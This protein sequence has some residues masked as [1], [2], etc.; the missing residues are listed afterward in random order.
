MNFI[1]S[2]CHLDFPKFHADLEQTVERAF[3]AGAVALIN[4]GV[5]LPTSQSSVALASRYRPIYAAVGIHPHDARTLSSETA[6]KLRRL[7][8]DAKVVAIG[9]IGLDYY[10]NLSTQ[11]VQRQA[12]I[13]QLDLAR[14][15]NKP[16]II[17]CRDAYSDA[18]NI[19]DE[20]YLPQ[21]GD[22]LPG[23]VHSF[24]AGVRYAQE[25]LKR[26]FYIGIN[27]MITYPGSTQLA[28]AVKIIPMDRILIETD[29]PFLAP[30]AHRGKRNEPLYVLEVAQEIA[31]I[32]DL[33]V[34]EVCQISTDNA[35]QLFRLQ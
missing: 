14:E 6:E 23:V 2:H 13:D 33:S 28:E 30:Q 29:A 9:E 20:H 10:R 16:I 24:S 1:D 32:K 25:F 35:R 4:I 12:F 11:T 5:D 7:G 27:G 3:A 18:L 21:L 26:G 17:H 34:A 31:K 22:R 8:R 19:L 15:L